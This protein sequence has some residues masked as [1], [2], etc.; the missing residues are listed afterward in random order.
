[1][2]IFFLQASGAQILEYQSVT[3]SQEKLNWKM[4]TSHAL[5]PWQPARPTPIMSL[6]GSINNL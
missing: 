4:K 6:I 2:N 1:M 5:V 3:E